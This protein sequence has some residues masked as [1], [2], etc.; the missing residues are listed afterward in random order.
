M[1]RQTPK[2]I[3]AIVP[4]YNE[5]S[6]VA[7]VVRALLSNPIFSEVICVDD[8]SSDR[9]L[10]ILRG[11][12][13]AITRIE[14]ERNRGKGNALARGVAA[15]RGELVLFVDADLTN[16]SDEH[17]AAMLAPI[18]RAEADAVLGYCRRRAIPNLTAHLTG[19]RVYRRSDLLP[20]LERMSPSRFGVEVLL[21][22][23]FQG[24]R[25]KMVPL[26]GLV[27]LT[28]VE[29][30]SPRKAAREYAD[31]VLEVAWQWL[32]GRTVLSR[33]AVSLNG[34]EW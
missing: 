22:E 3:S 10:R 2:T 7:S 11:F 31:E 19:Q 21:N 28:K 9:S 30:R 25:V 32:R 20:H 5:E 12:G 29:K 16:L 14:V 34:R 6:T 4:V 26:R 8:G 27:G 33:L 13:E 23:L 17:L 18:L 15:A 1:K 24:K